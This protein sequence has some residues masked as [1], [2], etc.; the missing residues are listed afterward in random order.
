MAGVAAGP[1]QAHPIANLKMQ[2][3]HAEAAIT[4]KDGPPRK[5]VRCRLT[6]GRPTLR[7]FAISDAPSPCAF[8]LAFATGKPPYRAL[9]PGGRR[10]RCYR[11]HFSSSTRAA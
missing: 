8:A 6:P 4:I 5:R 7:A 11:G 9:N 10:T 3:V 2:N 1:S